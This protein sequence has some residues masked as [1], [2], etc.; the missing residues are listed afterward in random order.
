ME[1]GRNVIE[2]GAIFQPQHA[3]EFSILGNVALPLGSRIETVT[4][5]IDV[6]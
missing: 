3:A 2:Q 4:G 6:G 5:A 1:T